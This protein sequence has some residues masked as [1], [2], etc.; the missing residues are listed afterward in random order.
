M[1]EGPAE[2][3]RSLGVGTGRQ[4]EETWFV[5]LRAGLSQLASS[6]VASLAVF[7]GALPGDDGGM[8]FVTSKGGRD[9]YRFLDGITRSS[10]FS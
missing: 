8:K 4:E 9:F 2:G 6:L 7:S 5:S 1:E 3:S 10:W